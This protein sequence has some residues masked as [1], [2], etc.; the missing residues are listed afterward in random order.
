MCTPAPADDAS[1]PLD[2]IYSG[3]ISWRIVN[4]DKSV[5][6]WSEE[7]SCTDLPS[8]SNYYVTMHTPSGDSY[9]CLTITEKQQSGPITL[10][11]IIVS[12]PFILENL[13]P[14][15]LKYRL[16][17]MQS[18]SQSTLKK[19]EECTVYSHKLSQKT[20]LDVQLPDVAR[21]SAAVDLMDEETNKLVITDDQDT[22]IQLRFERTYIPVCMHL[23]YL[24]LGL[25]WES[26]V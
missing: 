10:Y 1:V 4:E 3:R 22:P 13:L 21:W 16:S 15:P 11:D 18:V 17:S 19:G 26:H 6:S 14:C 23:F 25:P 7:L 9:L 24:A 2:L 20:L 5:S 8:S 12:A